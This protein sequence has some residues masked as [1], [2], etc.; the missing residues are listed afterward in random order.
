[1]ISSLSL[2]DLV[3]VL[4]STDLVAYSVLIDTLGVETADFFA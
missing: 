4:V 2:L 3:P 1:M